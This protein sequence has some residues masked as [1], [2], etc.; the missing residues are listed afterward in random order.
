MSFRGNIL[1]VTI[2]YF[3]GS[4]SQQNGTDRRKNSK[5][6]PY[7]IFTGLILNFYHIRI[8]QIRLSLLPYPIFTGLIL[9]CFCGSHCL[10]QRVTIPY[11]HG[12]YSQQG[13]HGEEST[14]PVVTIPYFHGS[15]SQLIRLS[16]SL[17][18]VVSYHT[19]F[20]RVLFSTSMS[21][22]SADI[23]SMLPYPIFTGLIL[24]GCSCYIG[25]KRNRLPYPIFTGLILN[26]I[27]FYL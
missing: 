3:H 13:E 17:R 27:S 9:N 2:P 19:L 25:H 4:Y 26:T 22:K 7:P 5:M 6:L 8:I 21:V 14:E 24:N 20:S 12:S 11:F 10:F 18:M 23:K 15:Y 16:H 1:T